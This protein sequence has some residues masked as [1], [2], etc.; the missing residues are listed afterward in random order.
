MPRGDL[1]AHL[2]DLAW[3]GLSGVVAVASEDAVPTNQ[4]AI[5]DEATNSEKESVP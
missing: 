2:T 5:E 4:G 3:A 1:A